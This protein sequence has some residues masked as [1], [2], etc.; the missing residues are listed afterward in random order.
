MNKYI[1]TSLNPLITTSY[2]EYYKDNISIVLNPLFD[3]ELIK[4]I[5]DHNIKV[6]DNIEKI[7][8]ESDEYKQKLKD[9]LE[10]TSYTILDYNNL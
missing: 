6:G 2:N 1:L 9:K 4:F 8:K 3:S 7:W 10:S 5:K